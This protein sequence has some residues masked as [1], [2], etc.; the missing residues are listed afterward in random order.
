LP[1]LDQGFNG[2][3][4]ELE[5]YLV[6]AKKGLHPMK[7][8]N[9][10]HVGQ[11]DDALVIT[12]IID[13]PRKLVFEA[14]TDPA[15]LVHWWAPNGCT[16][17]FCKVDLRVGG[18]IHFCMRMPDGLEIWGL[19]IYTEIIKPERIVYTDTFADAEGNVVT[20]A[21]YGMSSG[22][23]AETEVRVSFAEHDGKTNLT[24]R[25][26]VPASFAEREEMQQGWSQMLDRLS[27][28]LVNAM[29]GKTT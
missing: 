25:H 26:A 20:P 11:N 15:H 22:H 5:E 17:P 28:E 23:P 14:W 1:T 29:K 7:Q 12:R 10:Q 4:D 24:L 16:T 6:S 21:H 27:K 18:K 2:T 13:A 9:Y 19:G 3:M 8:T